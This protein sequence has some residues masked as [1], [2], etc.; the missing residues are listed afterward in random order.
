MRTS[1]TKYFVLAASAALCSAGILTSAFAGPERIDSKDKMV[2]APPPCDPRWYVSLGGSWDHSF[3]DFSNGASELI[4]VGDDDD[5]D[6]DIQLDI[7]GRDWDDA[8]SNWWNIQGEVGYVL[9]NHIELFGKFN[10]THGDAELVDGSIIDL[11]GGF[12]LELVSKFGDY[13]SFGGEFGMR[14]FFTDKEAR[15]RPYVSVS[16]GAA[17]V[18]SIGLHVE[19]PGLLLFGFP[20]DTVYDNGFYDDG[21]VLSVTGMLGVEFQV[22]PCKFSVG[23]EAGLNW[24][25]ELDGND[26]AFDTFLT[27]TP[28]QFAAPGGPVTNGSISSAAASQLADALSQLNNEGSRLSVPVNVYAKFRF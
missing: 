10:Y 27:G 13:D 1:L 14:Y 25:S 19:A 22:I 6:D 24:Q 2:L 18:D 26:S 7:V 16:G 17:F 20:D 15:I 5:D 12:P 9:T 8:Y 23:I 28:G 21:I 3:G 11:G 4:L